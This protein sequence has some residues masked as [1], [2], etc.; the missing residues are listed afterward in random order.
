MRER[1]CV[2]GGRGG[3]RG[4]EGEE[5]ER[6][7]CTVDGVRLRPVHECL[8]AIKEYQ[9]ERRLGRVFIFV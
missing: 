4:K 6:A 5:K 2:W 8:L 7:P 1:M 3:L 9:L